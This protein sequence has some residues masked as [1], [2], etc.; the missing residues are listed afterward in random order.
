MGQRIVIDQ[1]ERD[2]EAFG[3]GDL[4]LIRL[5]GLPGV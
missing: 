1:G 4:G 5:V 2:A 3:G